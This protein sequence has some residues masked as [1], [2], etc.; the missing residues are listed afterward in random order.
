LFAYKERDL[1]AKKMDLMG[2]IQTFVTAMLPVAELRLAIPIA[3]SQLGIPWYYALPTAIMGNSIPILIL[4]P[5]LAAITTFL[6]KSPRPI[7]TMVEWWIKHTKEKHKSKFQR[8]GGVALIFLVALPL[9]FTGA[10]TGAL[11]SWVFQIP[12]KKAI[13]LILLG[14]IIAGIIVTLFTLAGMK[15]TSL[16]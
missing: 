1:E 4:V 10:W 13:S 7:S 11:A 8:Y 3:I 2:I 15:I 5:G 6:Q 9:P 14:I 12:T 16:E